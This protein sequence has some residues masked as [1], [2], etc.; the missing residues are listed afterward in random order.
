[1]RLLLIGGTNFVG[2]ATVEEALRRGHEVTLFNRGQ[3]NP[4]LF[5]EV[6]KLRG[7]RTSDL[8]ALAGRTW[9]AVIDPST[10]VPQV[11]RASAELLVDA[12][13]HYVYISS[14]SAYANFTGPSKE[15]DA[16]KELGDLPA[17]RLLEDYSNYGPLKAL[18]EQVVRGVYG[19]RGTVVRPGL[20]V[21]A[22]DPTGRFTY[23]PHRIARGGDVVVPA[24]ADEQVQFI[25]VRDLAAW[26]LDITDRRQDGTFNATGAGLTWREL[27]E[28]CRDVAGSDANFVWVDGDFLVEQGVE[29]WMGLPLWIHD[30][31]WIGMHM[32]DVTKAIAAGLTF[33]PLAETV[34]ETLELAETTDAAGLTPGREDELLQ[35]WAARR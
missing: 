11:V 6:E 25:D 1:M 30:P 5:T 2:R 14:I 35:A 22:Y 12:V 23:W 32:A 13:E 27:V 33:R 7:D 17:D 3:T 8:I 21:G 19:S 26:L 4:E 31:E 29:E 15:D 10:S 24:P 34:R 18:S 28:T 9:D 20:I 16:T